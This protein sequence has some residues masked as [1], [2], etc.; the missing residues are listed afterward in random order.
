MSLR[1]HPPSPRVP[2]TLG[3]AAARGELDL[4]RIFLEDGANPDEGYRDDWYPIQRARKEGHSEVEALLLAHGAKDRRVRTAGRLSRLVDRWIF[5][6]RED[7]NAEWLE[8]FGTPTDEPPEPPPATDRQRAMSRAAEL[9]RGG[10]LGD[11]PSTTELDLT[12]KALSG[13]LKDASAKHYPLLFACEHGLLPVVEALLEAAVSPVC[14]PGMREGAGPLS[15]AAKS[16]H[17]EIVRLLL[18]HGADVAVP[19]Q[20]DRRLLPLSAAASRGDLELVRMLLDAGANPMERSDSGTALQAAAG[21]RANTV[22]ALLESRA[23]ALS[24]DLPPAVRSATWRGLAP[25]KGIR[26]FHE[27]W[28]PNDY[29]VLFVR[30][31]IDTIGETYIE[32]AGAARLE[33][34]LSHRDLP[35]N[36]RGHFLLQMRESPWT[37]ILFDLGR[38]GV[39]IRSATIAR[40]LSR[41]LGTVV[42]DIGAY[43]GSSSFQLYDRGKKGDGFDED[44]GLDAMDWHDEGEAEAAERAAEKHY[45]AFF[46]AQ[47][48]WLPAAEEERDGLQTRLVLY[49][50]EAEQVQRVDFVVFDPSYED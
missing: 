32:L 41:A 42:I 26:A 16:G 29:R 35:G 1:P 11:D 27:H 6:V 23:R 50:V 44:R 2:R 24:G 47:G 20:K 28:C 15:L 14:P 17:V 46:E 33:E 13:S 48:V 31:P 19:D 40:G 4:V 12:G 3:E 8:K 45:H 39:E 22:R 7:S 43:E 49:G 37:A 21:P 25:V 5:G 36:P 30:A 18:E 10:V 34:D 38:T 9:I